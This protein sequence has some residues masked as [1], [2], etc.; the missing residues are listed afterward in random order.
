[1]L[2]AAFAHWET[3]LAHDPGN[4]KAQEA[5]AL[6]QAEMIKLKTPQL[7]NHRKE[8]RISRSGEEIKRRAKERYLQPPSTET[9]PE[10]LQPS[11]PDLRLTIL[12]LGVID[13]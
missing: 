2:E 10:D 5:L 3:D 13:E 7:K 6:I 12:R 8:M 1:M 4:T 11:R 9:K